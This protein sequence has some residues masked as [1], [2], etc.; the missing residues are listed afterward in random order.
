MPV[1]AISDFL[2]ADMR[3]VDAAIRARLDSEVVLVRQVAEYIVGS[4]GKRLR[5]A[6]VVLSAGAFGY[7]GRHH[8]QLVVGHVI[9]YEA[10]RDGDIQLR[11]IIAFGDDRKGR[12]LRIVFKAY[13]KPWPEST[14]GNNFT[15]R[16]ATVVVTA[17]GCTGGHITLTHYERGT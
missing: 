9:I 8:H 7:Q 1:P 14:P 2:A 5:P 12:K 11:G 13:T 15:V 10:E 3:I 4:G 16:T 6:L 17:D